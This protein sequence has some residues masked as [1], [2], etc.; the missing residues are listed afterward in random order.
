[1]RQLDLDVIFEGEKNNYEQSKRLI[2]EGLNAAQ[3]T[4]D[5]YGLLMSFVV[6]AKLPPDPEVRV[7]MIFALACQYELQMALLTIMEGHTAD[8]SKH[9]RRAIEMAGFA[10]HTSADP[11][12]AEQWEEAGD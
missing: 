4:F 3:A 5:G 8:S 6:R 12:L 1:M 7:P 10:A 9:V 11:K 2:G